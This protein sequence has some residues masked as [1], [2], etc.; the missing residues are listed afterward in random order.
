[1]LSVDIKYSIRDLAYDVN[2]AILQE[3]R[4][5]DMGQISA[6]FSRLHLTLYRLHFF[7]IHIAAFSTV[8]DDVI[9]YV[10]RKIFN[11]DLYY[12]RAFYI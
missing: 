12:S 3:P 7:G 9:C 11:T 1:M 10:M 6:L 5:C 2:Y 4:S 8:T